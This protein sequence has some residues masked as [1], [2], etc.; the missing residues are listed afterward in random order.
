MKKYAVQFFFFFCFFISFLGAGTPKKIRLVVPIVIDQGAALLVQKVLPFMKHGMH[1]IHKQGLSFEK[2][3]YP[4]AFPNTAAGHAGLSTGAYPDTHGIVD[5]KVVDEKGV[6]RECIDDDRPQSFMFMPDGTLY[7]R[8]ISPFYLRVDTLVDQ[9]AL[10]SEPRDSWKTAAFSIKSR[11]SVMLAGHQGQAFWLDHALGNL[12]TSKAYFQ[13]LPDWV[14][15]FNEEHALSVESSYEWKPFFP[16][17]HEAYKKWQINNYAH[18]SMPSIFETVVKPAFKEKEPFDIFTKTP[19]G[20]QWILQAAAEYIEH[21]LTDDPSNNLLVWV[22]LSS[23]D[24]AGHMYGPSS[25][26]LIDMMYHLDAMIEQFMKRIFEVVDEDEVLFLITADHGIFEIPEV[27]ND[28][29]FPLPRRIFS[30]NLMKSMNNYIKKL[31]EIDNLVTFFDAPHFYFNVDKYETCTEK[32]QKQICR[33][34]IRFLKK[35]PGIIDAWTPE[36]LQQRMFPESSYAY[37]FKRQVYPGRNGHLMFLSEPYVMVTKYPQGT[38][39]ATPYWYDVHVPLML[40]QKGRWKGRSIAEPV[41]TLRVAS[42]LAHLMGVQA[43][44]AAEKEILPGIA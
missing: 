1:Q 15:Q 7:D 30:E 6:M 38:S 18:S 28:K 23:V 32:K 37:R 4:H 20:N 31:Y 9:V 12:T 35:V 33:S 8:G 29:G 25:M 24:R 17:H 41:S 21:A 5:N 42:T 2:A 13:K 14:I 39:H 43:P 40:Y 44:S 11:A 36:E 19:W 3:Y 26:E 27:L 16:L 10:N 22:S 34:L